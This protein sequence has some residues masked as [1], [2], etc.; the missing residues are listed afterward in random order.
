VRRRDGRLVPFDAARI[1][2]AVARAAREV[3]E[4]APEVPATVARAVVGELATSRP[5]TPPEVEQI[6]DAVERQLALA[7]HHRIARAYAE[8]RARRAEL[9]EAKARLEVRDDLKLGLAA[10][11]V[12]R[13]RY[14]VKDAHGRPAESTGE[15]RT[16]TDPVRPRRGPR[17]SRG[18]CAA[19]TSS[20]T[21]P[22]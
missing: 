6:Q 18:S 16:S 4:T 9:R 1:E 17:R 13:Q 12:L 21:R 14:L 10:V 7:G 19:S 11:S 5:G 20:P 3:G 8:Y 22:R 2:R 15:M